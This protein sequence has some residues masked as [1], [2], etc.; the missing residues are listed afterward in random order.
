MSSLTNNT[1]NRISSSSNN[2]IFS[3]PSSFIN[4]NNNENPNTTTDNNTSSSTTLGLTAMGLAAVTANNTSN[5]SNTE[6][7]LKRN[8]S[9]KL[10]DH[11]ASFYGLNRTLPPPP[12]PPTG[13]SSF[14]ITNQSSQFTTNPTGSFF[15]ICYTK[16]IRKYFI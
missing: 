2:T 1:T 8:I 15:T 16:F 7:D 12:P 11:Y 14:N 10:D 3:Q 5:A 6:C 4:N 9:S 13:T